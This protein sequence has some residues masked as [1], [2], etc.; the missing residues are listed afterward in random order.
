[1]IFP[2]SHKGHIG[3]TAFIR[4]APQ[5]VRAHRTLAGEGGIRGHPEIGEWR[6]RVEP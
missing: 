2:P 3:R 4:P 6:R 5:S 1:M